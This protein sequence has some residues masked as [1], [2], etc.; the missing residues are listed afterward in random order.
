MAKNSRVPEREANQIQRAAAGRR[1]RVGRSGKA[2]AVI[3]LG[4]SDSGGEP[5]QRAGVVIGERVG[6]RAEPAQRRA[7]GGRQVHEP[8]FSTVVHLFDEQARLKA[9]DVARA[10]EGARQRGGSRVVG[11]HD[12]VA[13]RA[14]IR[15]IAGRDGAHRRLRRVVHDLQVVEHPQAV[16]PAREAVGAWRDHRLDLGRAIHQ[17]QRG[18]VALVVGAAQRARGTG[19]V[20]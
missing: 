2:A 19:V 17:V 7:V 6:D 9:F 5:A 3:G 1:H 20:V 10:Q 13:A 15:E 14:D 8:V 16:L 4:H 11:A 12:E 18:R